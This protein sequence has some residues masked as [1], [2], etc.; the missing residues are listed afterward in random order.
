M[1]SASVTTG[2]RRSATKKTA[3]KTA[4]NLPALVE[5]MP[6]ATP[7]GGGEPK[8][9][10][11]PAGVEV[12]REMAGRGYGKPSLARKLGLGSAA[13]YRCLKDQPEVADAYAEG[14][15]KEEEFLVGKLRTAADKGNIVA[16]IFLLKSRH[17]YVEGAPPDTSRT[18]VIINLPDAMSEEAYMRMVSVQQQPGGDDGRD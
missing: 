6:N 8:A 12:V 11:T 2:A 9:I 18:N 13:F 15:A 3:S 17:G 16:A 4:S 1:G 10:I 14:K 7:Q 5:R